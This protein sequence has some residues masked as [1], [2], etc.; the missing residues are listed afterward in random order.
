VPITVFDVKGIAADRRD[1]IR[2]AVEAAGRRLS[3]PHEG[4]IA[5][6]PLR[7]GF[8]VLITGPHGLE[9]SV[10]FVVDEA[11]AVITAHVRAAVED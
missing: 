4:W 5:A 8:K 2:A 1:A 9:R 7:G 6:D 3:A 11:P 10:S